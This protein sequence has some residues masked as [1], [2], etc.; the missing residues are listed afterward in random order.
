MYSIFSALDISGQN[1]QTG[2]LLVVDDDEEV[3]G[4]LAEYF[5]GEGYRVSTAGNGAAMRRIIAQ[6][7]VD[8]ILL[9]LGLPG[10]DGLT[11]AQW[12]RAD[13]DIRIIILSGRGE[14]VDR[15]I[16]LE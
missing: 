5:S 13:S 4:L 2:H 6:T 9:D 16:G 8:L 14:T 3:C 1:E 10:E 11:L 12:I 15:I 7:P